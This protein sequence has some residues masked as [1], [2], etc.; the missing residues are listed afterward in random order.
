MSARRL[1]VLAIAAAV[2]LTAALWFSADRRPSQFADWQP[3]LAPGLAERINDVEQVRIVGAGGVTLV[4]LLRDDSGWGV[5]E[6]DGYPADTAKLR[7]LLLAAAQ[8]RRIEPKTADPELHARL[9]VE[10]IELADAGGVLVEI[11]GG[12]D[13]LRL[14]LGRAAATGRGTYVRD[15]ADPQSWLVDRPIRIERSPAAWLQQE[16]IDIPVNRI[17][18]VEVV[19][20]GGGSIRIGRADDATGDF[21]LRDL[22]AGREPVSDFI[23]DSTA[24]LLTGLRFDD[25]LQA[26]SVEPPEAVRRSRFVTTDGLRIDIESWQTEERTVARLQASL[27]APPDGAPP[28]ASTTDEDIGAA[29]E[30]MPAPVDVEAEADRLNQRFAGRLFVLPDFKAANLNRD[31]D[32]YLKPQG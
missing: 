22:P 26:D 20:P 2:L 28:T 24:G 18:E 3:A 27:V 9:G 14:L 23:A 4:T 30:A 13:P 21:E 5:V 16:L 15:A 25:V 32:A 8:A 1:L 31:P 10:S 7:E 29:E 12:G 6:R 11:E 17:T 19:A